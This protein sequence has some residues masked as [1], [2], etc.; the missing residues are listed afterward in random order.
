MR[1]VA[2][3]SG[4]TTGASRRAFTLVEAAL[5]VIIIAVLAAILLVAV[6][7]AMLEARRRGEQQLLTSLQLQIVHFKESHGFVPPL[8]RDAAP[9]PVT[10]QNEVLVH[11]PADLRNLNLDRFSVFTLP[12]F[13]LGALP[14]TV[15]GI[16]GFGYTKPLPP[17]E[18]ASGQWV[19]PFSRRGAKFEALADV[20]RDRNRIRRDSDTQIQLLDRWNRPIRYYRWENTYFTSG[21]REGEVQSWGIPKDLWP[22]DIF[23]GGGSD[24]E[25]AAATAA[26]IPQIRSASYAILSLGADGVLSKDDLVEYER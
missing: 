3:R 19:G 22:R 5:V 20:T 14:A 7:A 11:S 2:A 21:P 26:R 13:L 18:R 6:R 23:D 8:V 10:A 17:I 4:S 9:G 12:Y 25:K 1:T 15:D 16:D 24:E